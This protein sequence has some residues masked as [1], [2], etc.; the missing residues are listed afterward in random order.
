MV[1]LISSHLG[2]DR[3]GVHLGHSR[4][5]DKEKSPYPVSRIES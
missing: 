5:G 3:L 2:K 4:Y 1:S